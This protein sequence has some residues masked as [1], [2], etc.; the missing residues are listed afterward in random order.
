MPRQRSATP[1][2]RSRRE[3]MPPEL[4]ELV[5]ARAGGRC[6]RCGKPVTGWDGYSLHHRD[7]RGMGGGTGA[8][9][10]ANVVLLCGSGTTGCHGRTES[11]RHE[12]LALGFLVPNG[13]LASF[14]QMLR[15]NEEWVFPSEG[16]WIP[17]PP[18]VEGDRP[19]EIGQA[20]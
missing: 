9:T 17:A 13:T 5:I 6:D 1:G 18:P 20:S 11:Y 12:A 10:A 8:H 16:G 4:A 14:W 19:W 7:P 3:P 2:K 15:H